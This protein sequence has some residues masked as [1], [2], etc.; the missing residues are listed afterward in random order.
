MTALKQNGEIVY[1]EDGWD[2]IEEPTIFFPATHDGCVACGSTGVVRVHGPEDY[3]VSFESEECEEC[4]PRAV[5]L[6]DYLASPERFANS[7][8]KR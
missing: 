7:E 3:G 8:T 4:A 5:K 6:V 1:P 2:W